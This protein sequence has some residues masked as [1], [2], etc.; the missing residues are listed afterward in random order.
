MKIV[1]KAYHEILRKYHPDKNMYQNDET[2]KMNIENLS[3]HLKP[4]KVLGGFLVK[5]HNL[6]GRNLGRRTNG[7]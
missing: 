1:K 6:I 2:K 5:M 7:V 4:T 3:V